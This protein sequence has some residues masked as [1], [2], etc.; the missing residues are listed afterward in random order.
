MCYR[1]EIVIENLFGIQ[2]RHKF[3]FCM[4][5]TSLLVFAPILVCMYAVAYFSNTRMK[6]HQ[7]MA[8]QLYRC[9][10]IVVILKTISAC[11]LLLKHMQSSNI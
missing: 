6:T 5:I 4:Q 10:I 3:K 9:K 2:Y 7:R 1:N 11:I 8:V